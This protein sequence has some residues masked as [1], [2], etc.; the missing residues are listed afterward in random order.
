MILTK[1]DDGVPMTAWLSRKKQLIRTRI[2]GVTMSYKSH[3]MGDNILK[4]KGSTQVTHFGVAAKYHKQ[5]DIVDTIGD[6]GFWELDA[7]VEL[8]LSTS[9]CQQ[10]TGKRQSRKQ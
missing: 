3:K 1:Y 8:I 2:T 6:F 4:I 5:V 7:R 10:Q 9:E